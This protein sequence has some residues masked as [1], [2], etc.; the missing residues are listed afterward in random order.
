VS[1]RTWRS[2]AS[3]STIAEFDGCIEIEGEGGQSFSMPGDSGAVILEE[4]TGHPSALLFAGDGVHTT[5]CDL[6]SL[7]RRLGAWPL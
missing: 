1:S 4:E 5:A 2:T 3:R 6:G 7:C